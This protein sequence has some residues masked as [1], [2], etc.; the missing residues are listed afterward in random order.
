MTDKE[1]EGKSSDPKESD[2]ITVTIPKV[3][4]PELNFWVVSTVV[5]LIFS[6]AVVVNPGLLTS[7][8][9]QAVAVGGDEEVINGE[10]AGKKAI[11]YINDNF[12]E[13][14][15]TASFVSTE[16]VGALYKV[17]TNY[18]E[19]DIDVYISKNGQWLFISEQPIDIDLPTTTTTTTVAPTT[20][21][22]P[23]KVPDVHAFVMSHCPYGLQF[24]KAYIPVIELLGDEAHMELNFVSYAMHGGTEVYEELR[25]YCINRD[26]NEKFTE[27]LRCF[28]EDG[29]YERC[30]AEVGIDEAKLSACEAEVDEEF[31]ITELFEDE[32]TWSSG[33]YPQFPIHADLNSIYG[34][35][36]S[37]TFVLNDVV[38]PVSRSPEAIKQAICS[39]F[40][41]PPEDCDVT[42]SSTQEAPS[43]GP[44]GQ[45]MVEGSTATAQC[46]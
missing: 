32:S 13:P 30:I 4:M 18:K 7:I 40:I 5:L 17:T 43:F 28:V 25:M 33:V 42:L 3:K 41:N 6:V 22:E 23:R 12:V 1:K 44:M 45:G 11:D 19:N 10:Q 38:L 9:G 31:K 26:Q 21:L 46:S 8:T 27:Y 14:G 2:G 39:A 16:D 34:V 29:D 35:R 37:P 15:Q 20:E 24:M 36:G